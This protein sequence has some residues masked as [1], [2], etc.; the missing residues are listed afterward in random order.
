MPACALPLCECALGAPSFWTAV[1]APAALLTAPTSSIMQ[2]LDS[3]LLSIL[4]TSLTPMITTRVQEATTPLQHCHFNACKHKAGQKMTNSLVFGNYPA[5]E[6]TCT[7]FWPPRCPF[8]GVTAQLSSG[9]ASSHH[10]IC[11][12]WGSNALF[13]KELSPG[14][15]YQLLPV[16]KDNGYENDP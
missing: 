12:Q 14:L 2:F 10:S 6:S 16:S 11:C 7:V 13:H 15:P 9:F 1:F 5:P 3:S 4:T 8:Y